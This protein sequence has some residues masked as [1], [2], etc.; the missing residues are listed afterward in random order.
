[1]NKRLIILF[2][3]TGRDSSDGLPP[4]NVQRLRNALPTIA[5]DGTPQL[6]FYLSGVGTRGPN[7]PG[8]SVVTK[9][10]GIGFHK[11]LTDGY[12]FLMDSYAPGDQIFIFGFSRGAFAA[13]VLANLVTRVG[14][15]KKPEHRV[16]FRIA[17]KAYENSTL[18]RHLENL[19][20]C[21]ESGERT[22]RVH[23]VEVEVVGCWD[24]VAS[25]GFPWTAGGVSGR[26][27]H[28]TGDL[29]QGIKHAFHALALDERRRAFTPTLWFLPEEKEIAK[30]IKL[31]QCW[32]PG[33]H[34]NIGGGYNDQAL[35]DLTFAWLTDLC[36]PLLDFDE[37]YIKSVVHT[38]FDP[39]SWGRGRCYDS[40]RLGSTWLVKHR[41]PGAYGDSDKET[42]ETIHPSV[43]VR[44]QSSRES[45]GELKDGP[46]LYAP[47]ALRG[48][49]PRKSANGSWEW[50]KK[51]EG[52]E[53]L[54]IPEA[55]FPANGDA[56]SVEITLRC[57]T[58]EKKKLSQ[59][60]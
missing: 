5:P 51:E 52:K 10:F 13:R 55:L 38:H 14:I 57:G 42:K 23:E 25:L 24:T 1:M 46:P 48:F 21:I 27:K 20:Y 45:G 18:D 34:T 2:D 3:G 47:K 44:W 41:T 56:N 9:A 28:W 7:I 59:L 16:S 39:S 6:N 26:Y 50:V 35:A 54:V 60:I 49:E 22:L 8:Q 33:A 40:Y 19:K 12:T 15:F 11:I 53:V 31:H 30:N 58:G 4:T 37:S 29:S 32:F 17:M 36:R 43:R